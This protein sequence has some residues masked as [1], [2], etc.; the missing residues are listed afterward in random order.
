MDDH[1]DTILIDFLNSLGY[2]FVVCLLHFVR[3]ALGVA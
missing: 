3:I 1:I 2:F